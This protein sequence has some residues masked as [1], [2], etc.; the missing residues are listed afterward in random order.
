MFHLSKTPSVSLGV[1][2]LLSA[3]VLTG[4]SAGSGGASA[5]ASSSASA[6]ASSEASSASV[7]LPTDFPKS[8]PLVDGDVAAANGDANDGWTA[9]V[10][11]KASNGFAGAVAALK[12]AGFT[13]QPG[14]TERQATFQD[15]DY[16][17]SVST[18]GQSVTYIVSTR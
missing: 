9:T 11:P 16:S 1:I 4:C 3:G 5:P 17:V 14:A 15:A 8:V 13:E 2:A 7:A 6:S 10:S 18:P 12:K